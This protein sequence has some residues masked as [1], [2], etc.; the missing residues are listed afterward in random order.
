MLVPP[1][2]LT[3]RREQWEAQLKSAPALSA[4]EL[5]QQGLVIG[6]AEGRHYGE[7]LDQLIAEKRGFSS[8]LYARAGNHYRGL[9]EMVSTKNIDATIGYSAELRYAQKLHPELTNLVSIPLTESAGPLYAYAVI[10]KGQWGDKFRLGI[11]QA[12]LK[13]RGT[14]DYKEAMARWFGRSS[15]WE[16]EYRNKFQ[17]GQMDAQ[18]AGM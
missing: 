7:K 17:A 18:A 5:M 8:Q 13:L 9:A 16:A 6:I 11:N 4:T 3:L 1:L 10:P 2:E 15:A 14:D 12:I